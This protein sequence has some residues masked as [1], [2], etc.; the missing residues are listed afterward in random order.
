MYAKAH[1]FGYKPVKR[2]N[3]ANNRS[4]PFREDQTA[5]VIR[6]YRVARRQVQWITDE[7]GKRKMHLVPVTEGTGKRKKIVYDTFK[8]LGHRVIPHYGRIRKGRTLAEMVYETYL[9]NEKK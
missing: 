5:A 4:I 8:A 7:R 1:P 9:F 2:I 6:E 3:P